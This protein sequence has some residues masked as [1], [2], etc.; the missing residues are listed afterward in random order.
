[1]TVK[2]TPA[3]RDFLAAAGLKP[4]QAISTYKPAAKL[5]ELGFLSLRPGGFSNDTF[6][7]TQ[8]GKSWLGIE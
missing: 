7:I 4:Q 2:L 5:V 8:A 1:M 6:T 3:Q